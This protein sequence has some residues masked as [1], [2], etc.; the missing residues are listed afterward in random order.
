MG[1]K[2]GEFLFGEAVRRVNECGTNHR[3][4]TTVLCLSASD[5][6]LSFTC[7]ILIPA[8]D[9]APGGGCCHCIRL[10][11]YY[12]PSW[13]GPGVQISLLPM[14]GRQ[15]DLVLSFPHLFLWGGA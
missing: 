8:I 1:G 5:S 14:G 2:F 12:V 11:G 3:V 4:R 13:G 10:C 9:S 15:A 6:A 7:F